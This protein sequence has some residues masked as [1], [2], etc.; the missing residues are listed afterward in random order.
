MPD[1]ICTLLGTVSAN[2]VSTFLAYLKSNFPQENRAARMLAERAKE[3]EFNSKRIFPF[4]SRGALGIR[5]TFI[6]W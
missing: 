5:S 1:M 3:K 6:S 4:L 2:T